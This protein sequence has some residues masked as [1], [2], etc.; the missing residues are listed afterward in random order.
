MIS[1]S[2]NF[3]VNLCIYKSMILGN[4]IL[5]Y[6]VHENPNFSNDVIDFVVRRLEAVF[7]G[8]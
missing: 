4:P 1:P 3:L 7:V 5:G 6:I 2:L 8:P